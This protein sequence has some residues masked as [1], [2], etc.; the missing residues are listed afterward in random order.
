MKKDNPLSLTYSEIEKKDAD[1]SSVGK[2]SFNDFGDFIEQ[3]ERIKRAIEH[4]TINSL[5]VDY[6]DFANHVFF[7]SAV[8]KLDIASKRILT[9]YPFSGS[10][11]DKENY[12]FSGSGYENHLL[13]TWPSF[14]GYADFIASSEHYLTASDSRN[15]QMLG[16][17]SL[18]V[19]VNI[20]P[21]ISDENIIIQALSG[22]VSPKLKY[23]YDFY[24]SGA[25]DP[26]LK[27]SIYS[28]SSVTSVSAAYADYT[29][30]FNTVAALYD[31]TAGSLGLYIRDSLVD[32]TSISYN[33]IEHGPIVFTVGS[34]SQYDSSATNYD[35]YSGSIDEIRVLHTASVGWH[36][37][38]YNTT[39][40]SEDFVKLNYKFNESI[41]GL[42]AVD[43]VVVDYSKSALHGKFVNYDSSVRVSG[44]SVFQEKGEPIL[45]SIHSDVVA[46]TSSLETSASLYDQENQN[47]ILRLIPQAVLDLDDEQSGLYTLF[48]L[49]MGRYFD[50]LK[51]YVDQFQNIRVV[52]YTGKNETPDLF[53]PMLKKY[54]GMSVAESFSDSDPLSFLYGENIL[55]SGSLGVPLKDI[56]NQFWRRMMLNSPYL[57]KSKGTKAGADGLLNV[58]GI[59]KNFL[60]LKEFGQLSSKSIEGARITQTKAV[61]MLSVG[62][63]NTSLTSSLTGSYVKVPNLITSAM[64]DFTVESVVQLPYNSSS[65]SDYLETEGAIWQLVDE[66]QSVGSIVLKWTVT[67]A[68]N[69]LGKFT[70][71]GS[72]GQGYETGE[73]AVFDGDI[74]YIASGINDSKP[75]IYVATVDGGE[76][77]LTSSNVGASSFAGVFNG[78]DY[79]FVIGANSGSIYHQY[80][81]Q[82]LFSEFRYWSRALS[83]SEMQDHGLDFQSVGV[84]DP[85]EEPHPLVAHWP[86]ME[87]KSANAD[88]EVAGVLDVTQ[89]GYGGTGYGFYDGIN[90]YTKKENEYSYLSPSLDLSWRDNKIRVFNKSTLT[91]DDIGN[92]YN[93]MSIEFN[94]IDALNREIT[95][96]FSDFDILNKAI[97]APINKWRED[98]ED[99]E[100]YRTKF[101]PK[102]SHNINFVNFFNLYKWFDKKIAKAIQ[103]MLP[104]RADFI[105]GEFVVESHMLERPRY[106]YKYPVFRTPKEIPETTIESVLLQSEYDRTKKYGGHFVD[107]FSIP[108]K[109]ILASSGDVQV[110][111]TN[112]SLPDTKDNTVFNNNY[113]NSPVPIQPRSELEIAE[114]D[115]KYIE[116]TTY[117]FLDDEEGEFNEKN[118]SSVFTTLQSADN[119]VGKER[120]RVNPN[121]GINYRRQW[122]RRR[123]EGLDRDNIDASRAHSPDQDVLVEY[124]VNPK[125]GNTF[126]TRTIDASE[127]SIH[128]F[129]DFKKAIELKLVAISGSE[130]ETTKLASDNTLFSGSDYTTAARV[131][132]SSFRDAN[133]FDMINIYGRR[134][135]EISG[136]FN[137]YGLGPVYSATNDVKVV[138]G[139]IYLLGSGGEIFTPN[140][141]SACVY[142]SSLSVDEIYISGANISNLQFD[143]IFTS[144]ISTYYGCNNMLKHSSGDYYFSSFYESA[145]TW[146]LF[147]TSDIGGDILS[148]SV[149]LEYA[150]GSSAFS[151][152]AARIDAIREDSSGNIYVLVADVDESTP[153]D[154]IKYATVYRSTTG[155]SGSFSVV[156]KFHTGSI[157][158]SFLVGAQTESVNMI[159]DKNDNIYVFSNGLDL[160]DEF[161]AS[162]FGYI[163]RSSTG[164]TQ[165]FS[166][167]HDYEFS[168]NTPNATT[169]IGVTYDDVNDDKYFLLKE[170]EDFSLTEVNGPRGV[171]QRT[172]VIK[173]YKLDSSDNLYLLGTNDVVS[174]LDDTDDY[175]HGDP[176]YSSGSLYYSINDAYNNTRIVK[177]DTES[178]VGSTIF[179]ISRGTISAFKNYIKYPYRNPIFTINDRLSSLVMNSP[180]IGADQQ[181]VYLY[182]NI[183]N[184]NENVFTEEADGV[185][186]TIDPTVFITV[187]DL[188]G[189]NRRPDDISVIY[190]DLNSSY[191]FNIDNSSVTKLTYINDEN[192]FLEN[193]WTYILPLKDFTFFNKTLLS[194]NVGCLQFAATITNSGGSNYVVEKMELKYNGF[195]SVNGVSYFRNIDNQHTDRIMSYYKFVDNNNDRGT[196]YKNWRE[197]PH[198]M[199]HFQMPYLVNGYS[200]AGTIGTTEDD[201]VQVR[202]IGSKVEIMWPNQQTTNVSTIGLGDMSTTQKI[203][204]LSTDFV[205]GKSVNVEGYDHMSLFCYALK[206]ETGT[207]DYIE[208]I[209]ERKPLNSLPFASEPMVEYGTSGSF[210][211][212]ELKTLVYKH[213]VDY[214]DLSDV[215]VS[216]II[217]VPLTNTKEI[218]IKCR[219]AN[220]QVA[221]NSN[222]IVWSRFID[223]NKET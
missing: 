61:P 94:L 45:Y 80:G 161:S 166:T 182:T 9:K 156:D 2:K 200:D 97:G 164:L 148:G 40:N 59:N 5:K 197:F 206:R 138:D 7:D 47:Y 195:L 174:D 222:Y 81:T 31:A 63:G 210:A 89:N 207:K 65:Y 29:G 91:I 55:S 49:S 102:L 163:R 18:Y 35:F 123:L 140:T 107:S 110:Y 88:G 84:A 8:S 20:N 191:W 77:D 37:K 96:E 151:Y 4:R 68:D 171:R 22:S 149:V 141:N 14:V 115:G 1:F 162:S 154:P 178:G 139:Y 170:H 208:T 194:P 212:A 39:I 143:L 175:I 3:R 147:K 100:A 187:K 158:S 26:H 98:Y 71:T 153:A 106:Q 95:K 130:S 74:T 53:L 185:L 121:S 90:P 41:T 192:R 132:Y 76:L 131:P 193:T 60:P 217:D 160:E 118:I 66:A 183:E 108:R 62:T 137:E 28:G 177:V 46:F 190:K 223:T 215:E 189:T 72:D 220:G 78:S 129:S 56:R 128:Y 75:F 196:F 214:S 168:R 114:I 104:A 23:G 54:F 126:S 159:I 103:Q 184:N 181:G 125:F 199:G 64:A 112:T 93:Y 21:V 16:S 188:N 142:R 87:N 150:G 218:R 120:V 117:T 111:Q 34:G 69:F 73:L 176:I 116:Y 52:D 99:L 180:I 33:P 205:V 204:I 42:S 92:D 10:A 152:D 43:T 167:I 133:N 113:R 86:L 38:Y 136:A 219:H 105:G 30:S 83:E 48:S 12:A 24:L 109:S 145:G 213:E 32:S 19:S 211:T 124:A 119:S 15:T 27:F 179:S 36:K 172:S 173:A 58:L 127:D 169:I 13:N 25:N 6:S 50:E 155:D 57:L 203:G 135:A 85:R 146:R 70:L 157:N 209:I 201:I 216:Y 221:N 186:V 67:D 79:D 202:H 101:F 144:S 51:L 134:W 198:S 17:S 44:S 165:S 11:E 122:H 82:G